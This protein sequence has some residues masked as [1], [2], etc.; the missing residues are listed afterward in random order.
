MNC[1]QGDLAV[2]VG[3]VQNS[4]GYIVTCVRIHPH[5]PTAWIIEPPLPHY[6]GTLSDAAY[7]CNLRPIRDQDGQDE[8]LTWLDVPSKEIA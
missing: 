8:T 1:K 7:D 6:P 3:D 2:Y 5:W 4:L